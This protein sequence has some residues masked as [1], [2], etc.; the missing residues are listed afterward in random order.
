MIRYA[1][2]DSHRVVFFSGGY[3][4]VGTDPFSVG[5]SAF[6]KRILDWLYAPPPAGV[7]AGKPVAAVLPLTFALGPARPNP[8]TGQVA[9]SYSLPVAAQVNLRVFNLAGQVVQTLVDGR[10]QPGFKNVSWN[11]KDGSGRA[12]ASGVY[13]YRLE[14]GAYSAT[15]KA[16]FLR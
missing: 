12:L 9:I 16:V 13:F 8:F 10:E 15:R 2:P 7:E 1:W 3:E 6:L 14:A 4:G 11:G 5:P